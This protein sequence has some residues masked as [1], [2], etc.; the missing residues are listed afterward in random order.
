M[1]ENSPL[2]SPPPPREKKIHIVYTLLAAPE[3]KIAAGLQEQN[4]TCTRISYTIH[5]N[6]FKKVSLTKMTFQ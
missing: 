1:H 4:Y 3:Y 5:E 2:P 6:Q